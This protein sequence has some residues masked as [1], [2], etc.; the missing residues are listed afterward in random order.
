MCVCVFVCAKTKQ[1]GEQKFVLLYGIGYA[2]LEDAGRENDGPI[3]SHENAENKNAGYVNGGP[4]I[5]DMNTKMH[6]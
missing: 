6:D 5:R 2:S 1:T 4:E 3:S